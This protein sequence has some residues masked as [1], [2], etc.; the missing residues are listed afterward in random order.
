MDYERT[1]RAIVRPDHRRQLAE[2]VAEAV[3]AVEEGRADVLVLAARR[4]TCIYALLHANGNSLLLPGRALSDRFLQL[5]DPAAWSGRHV[6]L[7]DDTLVTGGTLGEREANIRRL[8]G[9]SGTVDAKAA[10]SIDPD[11]ADDH[12]A[13]HNQFASAFGEGLLPF[14]TDFPVTGAIDLDG[15]SFER[16]L[17]HDKAWRT[18]DV[19]NAVISGS[20][21][22]VYTLFPR[23]GLISDFLQEMGDIASIVELVKIRLFAH[24]D[25]GV[26][27][28]RFVPLVLT[29][30]MTETSVQRWVREMGFVPNGSSEQSAQ[31]LGLI[32][33]MLSRALLQTLQEF[34]EREF[35]L[36]LEEDAELTRLMIGDDLNG[37]STRTYLN[38]LRALEPDSDAAVGATVRPVFAWPNGQPDEGS[39]YIIVGDDAVTPGFECLAATQESVGVPRASGWEKDATTVARIAEAGRSNVLTASLAI[40]VLNDLGFA[41]PA[42]LSHDGY[43]FRGYRAGEVALRR[44]SDLQ[45]S[46]HGGRLAA[47]AQTRQVADTDY[48]GEDGGSA[49]L[50]TRS[51]G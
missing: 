6:I 5:A 49:D 17:A 12:Y 2:H 31:A 19:T 20:P 50:T 32:S 30:P 28:V 11:D 39:H 1:L 51:R 13:L 24:D 7:L 42:S 21:A 18:I 34:T 40:D 8:V 16:I 43:V 10:I 26:V 44:L 47:F 14:F 23:D 41:V 36:T 25:G 29:H 4:M 48:F 33:F 9:R 35:G 15:L 27:R 37:I 45:P 22:R 3:S 38:G 46:P